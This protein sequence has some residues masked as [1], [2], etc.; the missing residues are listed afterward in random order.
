M[1]FYI[2]F[3][4]LHRRNREHQSTIQTFLLKNEAEII[5]LFLDKLSLKVQ[6]TMVKLA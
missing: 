6:G 4:K 5:N 3:Q 2:H 1:P